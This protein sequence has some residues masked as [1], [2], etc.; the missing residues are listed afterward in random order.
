MAKIRHVTVSVVDD[1]RPTPGGI[2]FFIEPL[3]TCGK[4]RSP[5][6]VSVHSRRSGSLTMTGVAVALANRRRY[7]LKCCSLIV[8][9]ISRQQNR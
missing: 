7:V 2:C 9:E 3:F 6:G 5:A 8:L 4:S 1:P